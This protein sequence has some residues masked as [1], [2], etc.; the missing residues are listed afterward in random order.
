M[1]VERVHEK[2]PDGAKIGN[3]MVG[4]FVFSSIWMFNQMAK[5]VMNNEDTMAGEYY[6]SQAIN[7]MLDVGWPVYRYEVSDV[8]PL[9]TPEYLEKF[10]TPPSRKLR[11]CFDL[12]DTILHGKQ[13]D[14]PYGNETPQRDAVRFIQMLHGEGHHIIIYTARHMRTCDGNVGKVLA[15]QGMTTLKWLEDNKVPYDE[16]HFGKPHADI[17]VDDKGFRHDGDWLTTKTF[18]RRFQNGEINETF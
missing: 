12:D 14:E 2:H 16:I 9:G 18:I 8:Q 13:P 11:I 1:F 3:P 4:T 6:M 10:I 7:G 15:R 5:N 17:F